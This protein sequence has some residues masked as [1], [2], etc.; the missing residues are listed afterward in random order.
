M[1][2]W[3]LLLQVPVSGP[4]D[5]VQDSLFW[6]EDAVLRPVSV[7]QADSQQLWES[8]SFTEPEL[9]RLLSER[10]RRPFS[11]PS[12]FRRRMGWSTLR[13]DPYLPFLSFVQPTH[14][15]FR[16]QQTTLYRER[17]RSTGRGFFQ[18]GSLRLLLRWR[19][20]DTLRGVVST[21]W[22][23]VGHWRPG[24]GLGLWY[25]RSSRRH[26][27]TGDRLPLTLRASMQETVRTLVSVGPGRFRI[28]ALWPDQTVGMLWTSRMGVLVRPSSGEGSVLIQGSMVQVEIA[29]ENGHIGMG[30]QRTWTTLRFRGRIRITYQEIPDLSTTWWFRAGGIPLRVYARVY[31]LEPPHAVFSIRMGGRR[32]LFWIRATQRV[33]TAPST[34]SAVSA[35]WEQTHWWMEGLWLPSDQAGAPAWQMEA[36]PQTPF[37]RLGAG[38]ATPGDRSPSLRFYPFSVS[39]QQPTRYFRLRFRYPS[40]HGRVYAEV[41]FLRT[42]GDPRWIPL[43]RLSMSLWWHL[44]DPLS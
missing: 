37:L 5:P 33:E 20:R 39:L 12:D 7:N 23:A 44:S 34:R 6:E 30:M 38:V 29:R 2:V 27:L 41:L 10:R 32:S 26:W 35:G 8:G 40:S 4:A 15:T 22:F 42:F 31:G 18:R 19:S 25:A 13:L 17:V 24:W 14:L 3:L 11:S 28:L 16:L 21:P 1:W 43:L 9:S 36:G